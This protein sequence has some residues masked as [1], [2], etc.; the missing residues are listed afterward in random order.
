[1]YDPGGTRENTTIVVE[2]LVYSVPLDKLL[3]AGVST[4]TNPKNAPEFIK[5]LIDAAVKEM[6]KSRFVM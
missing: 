3:W 1:M 6:R 5:Q 4:T 2:T